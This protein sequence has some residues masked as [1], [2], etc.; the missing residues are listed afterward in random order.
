M[1]RKMIIVYII[2]IV[3]D[4]VIIIIII[5]IDVVGGV[6]FFILEPV[7]SKL[8]T[9]EKLVLLMACMSFNGCALQYH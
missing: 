7:L 2:I 4:N 6:P 8:V 5:A 9:I 3:T 1:V